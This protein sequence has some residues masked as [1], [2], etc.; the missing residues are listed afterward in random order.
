MDIVDALDQILQQRRRAG[1]TNREM[2]TQ[3]G[4]SQPHINDLLNHTKK[5]K[6]KGEVEVEKE[7][8]LADLKFETLLKLFPEVQAI[9]EE[10]IAQ[11][12]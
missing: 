5:R 12:E 1:I 8:S 3:A 6:K 4:C 9:L 7:V 11:Q 2:A 10:H